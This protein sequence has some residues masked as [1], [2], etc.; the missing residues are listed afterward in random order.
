MDIDREKCLEEG[1]ECQCESQGFCPVFGRNMTPHLHS[2]CKTREEYRGAFL[3]Q[4][5]NSDT[6]VA[7]SANK[8]VQEALQAQQKIDAAIHE[9]QEEGITKETESKGLGDT[10]ERVLSKLGITNKIM[11]TVFNRGGCGCSERKE[12]L[13]RIFKYKND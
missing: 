9:L 13:N 11:S 4:A 1:F 3:A 5:M 7:I 12:W 6:K 8:K 2:L 10:V